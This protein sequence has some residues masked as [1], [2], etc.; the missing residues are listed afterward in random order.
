MISVIARAW[1]SDGRSYGVLRGLDISERTSTLSEIF[2]NSA[3]AGVSD[4][5]IRYKPSG[6]I[7]YSKIS[8][9]VT[10]MYCDFIR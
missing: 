9:L 2:F 6:V 1:S 7:F 3:A 4:I 8:I 5:N 10:V